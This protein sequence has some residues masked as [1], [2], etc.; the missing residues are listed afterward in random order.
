MPAEDPATVGRQMA[1]VSERFFTVETANGALVLVRPVVQDVVEV[2]GELMALRSE[3]Q[4]LAL[5]ADAGEQL[6]GLRGRIEQKVE[7]LK[8]LVQEL[9]D[10]GCELK[11]FSAGL[12]DFP[13]LLDG[14]KVWLCWQLGEP[15]VVYWHALRGGFA[16]RR[17]IDAEFRGRVSESLSARIEDTRSG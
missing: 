3:R 17:P 11:D 15:E 7:R 10:V 16:G 6:D 9:A 2:Y 8:R 5:V 13:A 4:E 14:H 12:V 1:M